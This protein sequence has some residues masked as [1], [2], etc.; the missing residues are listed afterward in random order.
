MIPK[1][2]VSNWFEKKVVFEKPQL[3]PPAYRSAPGKKLQ[4]NFN[5]NIGYS[6]FPGK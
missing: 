2:N 6:D 1:D 4:V 5:T 3:I